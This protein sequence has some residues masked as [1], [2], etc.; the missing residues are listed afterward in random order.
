MAAAVLGVVVLVAGCSSEG[1]VVMVQPLEDVSVGGLRVE[2]S[3]D[4]NGGVCSLPAGGALICLGSSSDLGTGI[5]GMRL[6]PEPGAPL[7]MRMLVDPE[8][9][10]DGLPRSAVRVSVDGRRDL[11]LATSTA[12]TMCVTYATQ[13]GVSGSATVQLSS[14]GDATMFTAGASEP[15][16]AS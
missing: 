12:S 16:C 13:A 7:L 9:T 10:V 8:T 1:T 11:V 5:R 6:D 15:G 4:G 14:A 3:V 2:V